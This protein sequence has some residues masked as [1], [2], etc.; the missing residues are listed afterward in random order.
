[1]HAL[2]KGETDLKTQILRRNQPVQR[3]TNFHCYCSLGLFRNHFNILCVDDFIFYYPLV[4]K[5]GNQ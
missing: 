2:E 1:M 5:I 3:T 4:I